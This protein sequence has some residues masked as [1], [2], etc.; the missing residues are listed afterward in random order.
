VIYPVNS[1]ENRED[2]IAQAETYFREKWK[3]F[4]GVGPY[5]IEKKIKNC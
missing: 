2:E 3:I 1:G 5:Y 4:I